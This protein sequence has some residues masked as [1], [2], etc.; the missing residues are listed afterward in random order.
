MI[1]ICVRLSTVG[2]TTQH[3]KFNI[4]G[5]NTKPVIVTSK[6]TYGKALASR[7]V[8]IGDTPSTVEARSGLTGGLPRF[9]V[10][11]CPS[12]KAL[13]SIVVDQ[14]N[15]VASSWTKAWSRETFVYIGFTAIS[16]EPGRADTLVTAHPVDTCS[17]VDARCA[18]AVIIVDLAQKTFGSRR[19]WAAEWVD[20]IVACSAV[21]TRTSSTVIDVIL[22]VRT[23][24]KYNIV[25]I[26]YAY[27]AAK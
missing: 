17:A 26:C 25:I 27:K 6:R 8:G 23:L 24:H 13:T 20:E 3:K 10:P 18:E 7:R 21:L 9:T 4:K 11:P 15:T 14:L 2:H 16:D 1:H 5:F 12:F 22:T 19:T